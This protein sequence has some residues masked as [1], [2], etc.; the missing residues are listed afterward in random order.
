VIVDHVEATNAKTVI[1]DVM[2]EKNEKKF[3]T[4]AAG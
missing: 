4:T 1:T 2:D 3:L